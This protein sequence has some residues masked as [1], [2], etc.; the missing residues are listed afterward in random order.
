ME[1]VL[2]QVLL[3]SI[4]CVFRWEGDPDDME[5][6]LSS[7]RTI[8]CERTVSKELQSLLLE[9]IGPLSKFSVGAVS[10]EELR[11]SLFNLMHELGHHRHFVPPSTTRPKVY[12]CIHFA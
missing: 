6:I 7:I 1:D 4:P 12:I 8:I 2:V 3:R 10:A 9:A 11:C 5:F